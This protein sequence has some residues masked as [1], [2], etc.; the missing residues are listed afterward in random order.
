[1]ASPHDPAFPAPDFARIMAAP[2][3]GM[4]PTPESIAADAARWFLA[5][6]HNCRL[7]TAYYRTC[8][9]AAIADVRKHRA[10]SEALISGVWRVTKAAAER[11]ARA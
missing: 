2:G 7:S 4:T 6:R 10:A 11:R 5:N 8:A 3:I 1:M 9:R